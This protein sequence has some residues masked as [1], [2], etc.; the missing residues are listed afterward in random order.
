MA[1]RL[2]R[3]TASRRSTATTAVPAQLA[4]HFRDAGR[5]GG[6]LVAHCVAAMTAPGLPSHQPFTTPMGRS[7]THFLEM[8]ASW[9]VSTTSVTSLYDSGASSITSLGL[10]NLQQNQAAA[11]QKGPLQPHGSGRR[12]DYYCQQ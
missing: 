10:A 12:H 8:P 11:V 6:K 4:A 2:L 3:R 7:L 1:D 5:G 9:Q